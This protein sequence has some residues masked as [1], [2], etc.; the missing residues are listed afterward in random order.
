MIFP[1]RLHGLVVGAITVSV[2]FSS[3][4]GAG[5]FRK[6][7]AVAIGPEPSIIN[8]SFEL[9]ASGWENLRVDNSEYYSPVHGE[10]YAVHF[11]GTKP[12]HQE[13]NL[14]IQAGQSYSVTI[15]SRSL[16][17]VAV[18]DPTPVE[19]RLSY[20]S[21]TLASVTT[22]VA[23]VRLPGD[24]RIFTN[25]DGGNVWI[26]REYRMEFAEGI[27]YQSVSDDPLV[28]PWKHYFDPDY[29]TDMAVGPIITPLGLRGLYS[30]YYVDLPPF[31]SRIELIVADGDPLD[32]AWS[33]KGVV[34]SHSGSENPWAIDAHLY[35]DNATEKLWMT[36]GGGT[37]YVSELDP[38]DGMLLS[39]PPESEFNTHPP[40][41]HTVVARWSGDEWT[42]GNDWFEGASL[43][44]HDRYWYLLASY[45]HLARNYT[46]RMGRG[47]SPTGP[48]YDRDGVGLLE[49]DSGES[50]YG[51]TILLGAEGGQDCPGHP[52]IWEEQGEYYMGYDYVDEYDHSRKDRFGIRKLHWVD[53]WPTIWTPITAT[54]SADDHPR[55]IGKP[56]R[57]SLRN[58]G[59][60][61]TVAAFD[62]I[63]VAVLPQR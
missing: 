14:V 3:C 5:Q 12:I 4:G 11:G 16:N 27:Y 54:F 62:R 50:E 8:A 63:S 20:R 19:V 58:S 24:P 48:F 23:P 56:L 47:T 60:E 32:Y 59:Q 2:M 38:V 40:D 45:G 9:G 25:D 13:T 15:W 57:I 28:D 53:D 17:P 61:S 43:Q 29:R 18:V 37:V 1:L 26:D 22:D 51:N 46:I 42:Q 10:A 30:T 52:H 31:H 41:I 33:R 6:D 39:H 21:K 34:L 49:W 55:S 7:P 35:F 36:W 44:R